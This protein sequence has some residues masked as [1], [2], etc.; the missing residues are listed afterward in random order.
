[1]YYDQDQDALAV[2]DEPRGLGLPSFLDE[3]IG[4]IMGN[5]NPGHA[6]GKRHLPGKLV[7]AGCSRKCSLNIGNVPSGRAELVIK[8]FE[9]G[10]SIAVVRRKLLEMG[11][12]ISMGSIGRHRK[13]HLHPVSAESVSDGP[14]KSELDILDIIIQRGAQQVDLSSTKISAEQL[15][16]A[17]ELKQKMTEGSVFQDM[18]DAMRGVGQVDFD[19]P[20]APPDDPGIPQNEGADGPPD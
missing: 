6:S 19:A 18:F 20:K 17:I 7:I 13:D 10:D 16:R 1:L 5:V 2:D 11:T 4:W 14:K 3:C 15:L 12:V 8:W 9:D